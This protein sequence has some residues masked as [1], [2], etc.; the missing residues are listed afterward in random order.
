MLCDAAVNLPASF[1]PAHIH[2][3]SVQGTLLADRRW[4]SISPESQQQAAQQQR[5]G[6]G[7]SLQQMH[8]HSGVSS[9]GAAA[10]SGAGNSPSADLV[11]CMS[12]A[13][14]DSGLCLQMMKRTNDM[15]LNIFAADTEWLDVRVGSSASSTA[16]RT[17]TVPDA[18]DDSDDDDS[19]PAD[20]QAAGEQ[21]VSAADADS[22]RGS[23]GRLDAAMLGRGVRWASCGEELVSRRSA[24]QRSPFAGFSVDAEISA[25]G[26]GLRRIST[27]TNAPLRWGVPAAPPQCQTLAGLP[28]FSRSTPQTDAPAALSFT[29]DV[30]TSSLDPATAEVD[31]PEG[32]VGSKVVSGDAG[33]DLEGGD[34]QLGSFDLFP[35][36]L[37]PAAK[38]GQGPQLAIIKILDELPA[39]ESAHLGCKG[40]RAGCKAAAEASKG[41]SGSALTGGSG[42]E[43]AFK[44]YFGYLSEGTM[45]IEVRPFLGKQGRWQPVKHFW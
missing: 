42:A 39:D 23:G 38:N 17:A 27:A 14:R 15:H 20:A 26:A 31:A 33:S 45:A 43:A 32:V 18:S 6:H 12:A 1:I 10:A 30:L 11:P 3:S 5:Q 13:L 24:L 2:A 7:P 8:S 22:Q 21:Q 16:A 36:L 37:Q 44:F 9:S 19:V 34:Q 35:P 25:A 40:R 41:V 28:S 4:W 29:A